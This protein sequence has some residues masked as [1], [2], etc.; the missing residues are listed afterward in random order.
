M[1]ENKTQTKLDYGAE[2]EQ[3]GGGYLKLEDGKYTILPIKEMPA[4]A[5]KEVDFNGKKKTIE[6]TDWHVSTRNKGDY[7][8]KDYLWSITKAQGKT[9]LWGQLMRLGK[10]WKTLAQKPFTL[11]VSTNNGKK[12]YTIVEVADLDDKEVTT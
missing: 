2:A 9:T 11:I 1:T 6:Q 5:K 12:Q 10:A 3:L 4:P 7:K 8:P